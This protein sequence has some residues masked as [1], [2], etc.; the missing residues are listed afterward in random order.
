VKIPILIASLSLPSPSLYR[1]EPI[2]Y[3]D[4]VINESKKQKAITNLILVGE[5]FDKTKAFEER[6]QLNYEICSNLKLQLKIFKNFENKIFEL[7]TPNN[8]LVIYTKHNIFLFLNVLK[9]IVW[10]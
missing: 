6:V 8:S 2:I 4:C 10:K 5:D 9:L 3:N 7:E 1:K